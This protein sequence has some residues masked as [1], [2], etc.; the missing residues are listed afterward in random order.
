M[1][2]I[3]YAQG[4]EK[5]QRMLYNKPPGLGSLQ[6]GAVPPGLRHRVCGSVQCTLL[7][8]LPFKYLNFRFLHFESYI[9][10]S[11]VIL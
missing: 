11:K 10:F 7:A 4:G 2:P 3:R 6:T 9:K 1:C 5:K 8:L